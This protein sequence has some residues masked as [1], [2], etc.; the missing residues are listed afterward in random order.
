MPKGAAGIFTA[1]PLAFSYAELY[2]LFPCMCIW[3]DI[4]SIVGLF[5]KDFSCTFHGPAPLLCLRSE[6]SV[7]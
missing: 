1:A 6:A 4:T 5:P 2:Q 3:V 7:W